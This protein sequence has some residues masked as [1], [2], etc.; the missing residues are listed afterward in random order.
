MV[1]LQNDL[2]VGL[3]H[4]SSQDKTQPESGNII[5]YHFDGAELVR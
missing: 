5:K 3:T 4:V 1:M 2:F